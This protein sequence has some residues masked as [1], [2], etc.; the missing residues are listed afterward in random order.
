MCVPCIARKWGGGGRG[1]REQAA[2]SKAMNT[3]KN[4]TEA[5]GEPRLPGEENLS[6]VGSPV[7]SMG[8]LR[9]LRGASRRRAL[10]A[11]AGAHAEAAYSSLA[12]PS[13]SEIMRGRVWGR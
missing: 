8:S 3:E 5:M 11:A 1:H 7:E 2:P 13:P 10:G 6:K 12:E 4:N 9:A